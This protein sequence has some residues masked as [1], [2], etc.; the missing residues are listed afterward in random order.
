[1]STGGSNPLGELIFSRSNPIAACSLRRRC[2]TMGQNGQAT[3]PHIVTLRAA[4]GGGAA[5]SSAIR[6]AEIP[7]FFVVL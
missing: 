1:M 5:G 2:S 7:S 4:R 3:A 6:I